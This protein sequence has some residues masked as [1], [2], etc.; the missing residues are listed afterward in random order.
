MNRRVAG[1]VT[2]VALLVAAQIAFLAHQ[3][4]LWWCA[5]GKFSVWASDVWSEHNSQH[6]LDAYSFSHLL[7]GV[8]FWFA[9]ARPLRRFGVWWTVAA[10]AAA[11]VFWEMLENS[12]IIIDRYRSAT[13]ALG[14]TGDSIANSVSDVFC[15]MA[16]AVLARR[17]GWKW[18]L[19]VFVVLEVG[20]ALWVRDNLTLNVIMLLCP[21]EAIKRWQLGGAG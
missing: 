21:S 6:I 1:P 9:F 18:S 13:A 7:H 16:G 15:C 12:A 14:Y 11:E 17:I 4:R 10:C 2:A 3:G 5:C 20:C 8:I 19:A